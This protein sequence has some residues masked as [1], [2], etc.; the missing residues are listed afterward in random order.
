MLLSMSVKTNFCEMTSVICANYQYMCAPQERDNSYPKE[1]AEVHNER[2]TISICGM[3]D[4]S[5]PSLATT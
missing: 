4:H 3:L 2:K 1:E 5:S